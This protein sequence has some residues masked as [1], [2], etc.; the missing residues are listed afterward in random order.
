MFVVGLP[1][2][3]SSKGYACQCR[4]HKRHGFDP[5]LRKILWRRAWQPTPM[6]LPGESKDR[7]AWR[8]II[9]W[10]TKDLATKGYF[11]Y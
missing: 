5:W 11:L 1:R 4:R 2:C 6:F 3:L 7:G 8:A 10:V 9:H